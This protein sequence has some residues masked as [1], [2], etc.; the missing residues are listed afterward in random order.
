MNE[1][2]PLVECMDVLARNTLLWIGD[3]PLPRPPSS[4]TWL[5]PCKCSTAVEVAKYRDELCELG[6]KLLTC[7]PH[8]V[9]RI[10]RKDNLHAYA[11]ELGLQKHLPRHYASPQQAV[12]PCMLKAAV[13][14]H[15]KGIYIVN[16]EDNVTE[17]ATGGFDC[18]KWLLQ[19]LCAGNLEYATSLLVQ[20]GEILDA[21]TTSYTYD[22]QIY[23]WP[24]VKEV[25]SRVYRLHACLPHLCASHAPFPVAP[26]LAAGALAF[27]PPLTRARAQHT[28]RTRC[29]A[30]PLM[31]FRQS[32]LRR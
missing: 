24:D 28:R 11:Q 16:S 30:R 19:E 21:I 12:Y 3:A 20:D 6:W 32:T 29:S 22:K 15:G 4:P 25:C 13:G 8:V 27:S 2:Q 26:F 5:L 17:K 9:L 31:T 18:G 23:V 14:D 7:E 10:G 1:W